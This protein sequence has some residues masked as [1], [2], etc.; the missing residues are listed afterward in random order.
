M[1]RDQT[2]D[3]LYPGPGP[4]LDPFPQTRVI[5]RI[6]MATNRSPL[7]VCPRCGERIPAA[8]LLIEYE[9]DDGRAVWAE[10]PGCTE[11]VHP[12]EP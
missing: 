1:S 10:C 11:V 5:D 3:V 8:Q 4:A 2:L 7:G 12:T 6:Q 9:V